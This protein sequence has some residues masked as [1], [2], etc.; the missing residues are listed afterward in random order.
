ME[1]TSEERQEIIDTITEKEYVSKDC[2][3]TIH[4]LKAVAELEVRALN[5]QADIYGWNTEL[6]DL[7]N[8][9]EHKVMLYSKVL[10]L[11]YED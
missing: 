8:M 10:E 11:I 9:A 7:K 6:L 5:E 1:L 2:F 3:D 4:T